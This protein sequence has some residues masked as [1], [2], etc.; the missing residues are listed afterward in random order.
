MGHR[1]L[2]LIAHHTG[3]KAAKSAEVHAALQ[4]FDREF[5][6][7]GVERRR[8]ILDHIAAGEA[9]ESELPPDVL[10]V[11]VHNQDNL[12]LTPEIICREVAF[13]LLAGAHT[14]ATAFTRT[15]HNVFSW[16]A[17]HPEAAERPRQDRLFCPCTPRPGS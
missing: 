17:E 6:A 13:Y 10:S 3:D 16:L 12:D 11:L 5:L 15:M 1:A 4:A 14:S 7:P 9:E 8:A 2:A